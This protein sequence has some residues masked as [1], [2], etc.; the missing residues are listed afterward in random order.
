MVVLVNCKQIFAESSRAIV[1][2]R[3]LFWSGFGIRSKEDVVVKVVGNH[4]SVFF[5]SQS[6]MKEGTL[7]FLMAWHK[8]ISL[9][10]VFLFDMLNV[11]FLLSLYFLMYSNTP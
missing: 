1:W 11:Y 4:K 2:G 6:G 8:G 3:G 5:I 10:C 9:N 7:F